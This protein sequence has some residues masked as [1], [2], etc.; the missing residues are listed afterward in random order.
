MY[1]VW[2]CCRL[3]RHC[4]F[5]FCILSTWP[6]IWISSSSLSS[7]TSQLSYPAMRRTRKLFYFG[8]RTNEHNSWIRGWGFEVLGILPQLSNCP[9]RTS[10]LC[11][12]KSWHCVGQRVAMLRWQILASKASMAKEALR[13]L[14]LQDIFQYLKISLT[15][16]SM[17]I[18]NNLGVVF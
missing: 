4:L 8:H 6:K 13:N 18:L 15:N 3:R 11:I 2:F 17:F 10:S 5:L 14:W 12:A 1:L 16:T 7:T 9:G